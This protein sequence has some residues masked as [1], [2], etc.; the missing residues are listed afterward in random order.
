MNKQ[1][2]NYRDAAK[3]N[4]QSLQS[5]VH[6][7]IGTFGQLLGRRQKTIDQMPEY[8][9]SPEKMALIAKMRAEMTGDADGG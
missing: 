6:P 3:Q 1:V 2:H 9:R 4:S 8:V 5:I 7:R